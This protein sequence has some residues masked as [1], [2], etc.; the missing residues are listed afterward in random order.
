[1]PKS[2]AVGVQ[3]A[4]WQGLA[5]VAEPC[6]VPKQEQILALVHCSVAAQM[7]SKWH[8]RLTSPRLFIACSGFR[9]HCSISVAGIL[10]WCHFCHL[11]SHCS[12]V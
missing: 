12:D 6:A 5:C 1:M 9:K 4:L 8:F 3:A 2:H 10:G 7:E 11:G